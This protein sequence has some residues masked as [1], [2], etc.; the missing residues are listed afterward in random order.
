VQNYS[1][2][3]TRATRA[4]VLDW[5]R[6]SPHDA[7]RTGRLGTHSLLATQTPRQQVQCTCVEVRVFAFVRSFS[8]QAGAAKHA[9]DW[10]N[11]N[12]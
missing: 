7:F 1:N 6:C 3:A 11:D 2:F 12:T 10:W 9:L 8:R 5:Q 4:R